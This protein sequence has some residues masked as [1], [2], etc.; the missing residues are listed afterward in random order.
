MALTGATGWGE[1]SGNITS[2]PVFAVSLKP[3]HLA[4]TSWTESAYNKRTM[5]LRLGRV[6][7]V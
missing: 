5:H 7:L 2:Q 6:I 3:Q 1:P 4:M